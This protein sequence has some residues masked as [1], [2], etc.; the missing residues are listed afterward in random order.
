VWARIV[1]WKNGARTNE[2]QGGYHQTCQNSIA[3]PQP[4]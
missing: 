2:L 3:V 4:C 1:V